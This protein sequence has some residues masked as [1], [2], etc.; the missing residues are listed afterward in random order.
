[1]VN[2]AS[3]SR[4][5]LPAPSSKMD[6]SFTPP[7][8]GGISR[9]PPAGSWSQK[10]GT[11]NEHTNPY[12]GRKPTTAKSE[13]G[14]DAQRG[15]AFALLG[16]S[17]LSYLFHTKP[18][19]LGQGRGSARPSSRAPPQPRQLAPK[20][21]R[22]RTRPHEPAAVTT[23]RRIWW[24]P[25]MIATEHPTR[26]SKRRCTVMISTAWLS[27]HVASAAPILHCAPLLAVGHSGEWEPQHAV[28]PKTSE[29]RAESRTPRWCAFGTMKSLSFW[30]SAHTL[31]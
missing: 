4:T 12:S 18:P 8:L 22:P 15:N 24:R 25:S 20:R 30:I 10:S 21:L 1:M 27:L 9:I 31:S 13:K 11:M 14:P 28:A 2:S 26:A 7:L 17:S 19:L 29:H 6:W 16:P 5:H 3:W 23:T